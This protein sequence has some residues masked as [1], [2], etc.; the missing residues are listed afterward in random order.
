MKKIII[1][2][3]ALFLFSTLSQASEAM[4]SEALTHYIEA[5]QAQRD[6]KFEKAIDLYKKAALIDGE[7]SRWAK[8]VANNIG[9]I[10]MEQGKLDEAEASFERA[11][12]ID[13]DYTAAKMN[14]GLIYSK[15][16]DKCKAT[17]YWLKVLGF[18]I[19]DLR[20][21]EPLIEDGTGTVSFSDP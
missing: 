13:P 21:H 6:G 1:L 16:G 14:L 12:K 4:M 15:R 10:H 20:P 9:V 7:N 11:L 2:A 18:N 5:L 8:F 3:A 19:D 17:E